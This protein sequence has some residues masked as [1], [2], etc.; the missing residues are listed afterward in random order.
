MNAKDAIRLKEIEAKI[1]TVKATYS[2]ILAIYNQVHRKKL[3][4]EL[5]VK[6]LEDQ[7]MDLLQ[8][9]LNFDPEM[10]F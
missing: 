4:L 8:G 5:E 3:S 7:K 1:T 2:E 10:G 6:I 9:Q